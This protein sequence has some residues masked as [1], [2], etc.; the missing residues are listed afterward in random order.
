MGDRYQI[1]WND[2]T[3]EN[4]I[5]I[6]KYFE[7]LQPWIE[8]VMRYLCCWVHSSQSVCI[9]GWTYRPT[10]KL[11]PMLE[12]LWTF[13]AQN[14]SKH[15]ATALYLITTT[16]YNSA[17]SVKFVFSFLVTTACTFYEYCWFRGQENVPNTRGVLIWAA[18]ATDSCIPL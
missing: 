17:T 4:P 15:Y 18:M 14:N 5:M 9:L 3:K 1:N 11:M 13:R 7:L 2:N 6:N 10:L 16:D 8:Y 12:Y